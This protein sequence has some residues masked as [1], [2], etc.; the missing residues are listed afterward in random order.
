MTVLTYSAVGLAV[1]LIV[2][3]ALWYVQRRTGNAGIV[4]VGWAA[5]IA[6]LAVGYSIVGAAPLSLRV[7]VASMVGLWG[8]RLAWHIHQRGHGKPEDGRY[9]QLR[10]D[11]GARF[12]QKLLG[13]YLLQALTVAFF[14]LPSALVA[15]DAAGEWSALRALG[16]AIWALGWVGES[17]ADKQLNAF[18]K[19]ASANEG[20]VCKRGLWRYSRHPNYF[21]EWLT[22]VGLAVFALPSPKG[23][24]ALACPAAMLYLLFRVTGIP[25]TEAQ[26]LRSKGE[27]YR[28]YQRETSA[29]FPW[30]PKNSSS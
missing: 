22:W 26:A 15:T 30:F 24:L 29:F 25:A 3:T 13:F 18:K 19:L 21:F 6:F 4:D 20:P 17:I 10:S 16:M 27:A 14:A 28:A 5:G 9:A 8:F 23:A 7:A 2:M 1:A 12:Q 11:W